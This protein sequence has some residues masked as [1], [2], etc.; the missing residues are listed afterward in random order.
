MDAFRFVGDRDLYGSSRRLLR[1]AASYA[2]GTAPSDV[3]VEQRC[4]TCGG[5]GHGRPY[6]RDHPDL[7]VSLSRTDG[8]AAA[9]VAPVPVAVDVESFKR[10]GAD[11]PSNSLAFTPKEVRAFEAISAPH[12]PSHALRHWVRKEALV[13]LGRLPLDAMR[14]VEVPRHLVPVHAEQLGLPDALG[15]FLAG[16]GLRAIQHPASAFGTLLAYGAAEWTNADLNIVGIVA[17]SSPVPPVIC[18]LV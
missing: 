10:T 14:A 5:L 16:F 8:A 11:L 17:A 2:T 15:V 4:P 6:L 7:H 9:A 13:K 18:H 12:R 3:V 1:L